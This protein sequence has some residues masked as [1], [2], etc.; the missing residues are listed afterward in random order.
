MCKRHVTLAGEGEMVF[1]YPAKSGQRR[2]QAVVDPKA[3]AIVAALKRRRGGGQELLAFKEGRRWRDVRSEDINAYIKQATS[4][5][6]SAKDFRTWNAT[7]LAAVA[8]SVS[9][10]AAGTKTGRERAIVRAV[11]EVAHYLGNTPA[12]C[13]ASYIDPRVFDA[14]RGGLVIG[15]PLQE[16]VNGDDGR[17]PIHHRKLEEAV[18]D[19]INERESSRALER[20]AA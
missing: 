16:A 1:D 3:S 18:L 2:I 15:R 9:G 8:L 6:F 10:E 13:R 11:K 7:V 19:L 20:V 14:Y 17:L 5:D 12:V 4:E